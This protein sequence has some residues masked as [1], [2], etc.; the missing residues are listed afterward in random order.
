MDYFTLFSSINLKKTFVYIKRERMDEM[1][2]EKDISIK[3]LNEALERESGLLLKRR[4]EERKVE[5]LASDNEEKL[6]DIQEQLSF[7]EEEAEMWKL[8]NESTEKLMREQKVKEVELMKELHAKDIQLEQARE[9]VKRIEEIS[10][11]QHEK[12]QVRSNFF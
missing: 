1:Q 8:R 9:E 7:Y 10:G 2:K 5:K 6:K 3:A 12:M 11:L 4:E